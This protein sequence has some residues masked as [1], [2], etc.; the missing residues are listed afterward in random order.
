[1]KLESAGKYELSSRRRALLDALM[2][3]EGLPVGADESIPRR[4]DPSGAPLSFAQQRMWFLEQLEPGSSAYNI[5]I[6]IRMRGPLAIGG[7]ERSLNAVAARH[8]TLRAAF[9]NLDGKAVQRIESRVDVPLPVLDLS[10]TDEGE[11]EV[12]LRKLAAQEADRTFDLR[13]APLIR[14]RLTRLDRDDHVLL[15]TMHHIVSDAWSFG[16][17]LRELGAF[18]RAFLSARAPVLPELPI[19]YADYAEWQTRCLQGEALESQLA[20]W[21]RQL[22]G[23]LP[24]LEL[25]V[26]RLR[27]AIQTYRGARRNIEL[28]RATLESLRELSRSESVTLFTTFLAALSVLL[29]KYSGDEDILIGSPVAGRDK[30]EVENLIGFF[31]NTLVLRMD[32]SGDPSFR[33]VMRRAREVTLEAY[34]H[35]EIPFEKLVDELEPERQLGRNPFF[36]VVLAFQDAPASALTF[37]DLEMSF[38]EVTTHKS[39]FD[40]TLFLW[41]TEQGL[42]GSLEYNTDLF[43]SG[44]AG[45]MV[46]HFETLLER[47]SAEPGTRLADLCL[48]TEEERERILVGWNTTRATYPRD[49]C[50]HEFIQ[51]QA[52]RTPDAV[53]VCREGEN[54]TYRQ[55][56]ER[57]NQIMRRLREL[58]VGPEVLVGVCMERSLEMVVGLLAVLKAG[59]A[60]VALDPDYPKERLA[61]MV[62]DSGVRVVLT[63]RGLSSR[64][65]AHGCRLLF[66]ERGLAA[67][68]AEESTNLSSPA[69]PHNLAYVTYTS[70][71]TGRPKGV[72][73]LHRGVL[74]LL[75]DVHYVR[76]GAE[77]TILQLAPVSFDA[78]TFEIWGALL[79]GGR[80]V[81]HSERVPSPGDLAKVI[82]QQSV[83]TLW[84]TA[85]LFNAIIDE[86]PESLAGLRQ[87]LTGGEALSVPH[88][89]KALKAL[90]STNLINGYGPTEGTTF[91]CC[92]GISPALEEHARSIPIG[93]PIS[94]TRVYILDERMN[95][96]PVGIPG[97]LYIGGDGLGR[98]YLGR[99]GLTAE[100]FVPDPFARE[101]GQRLYRSGDRARYLA[102]GNIEFLGRVDHQVKLRGFRVELG[103]IESVLRRHPGVREAV[104]TIWKKSSGEKRLAAYFTSRSEPPPR[105]DELRRHL[106]SKL[107]DYMVPSDFVPLESMPLG[108]TGKVDRS[109]LPEPEHPG[110]EP[111][112]PDMAPRTLVEEKLVDIWKKVLGV[113]CVG[114]DDNFFSLG[115]DSI[116]T[117]QAVSRAHRA[118]LDVSPKQLFQHQ[119]IR[120]L[121]RV[122]NSSR[123]TVAEQGRVDGAVPLTPIQRWYF[124]HGPEEPGHFNQSMFLEVGC[125]M[126]P[127]VLEKAVEQVLSDH[128]ALR[129]RFV[130]ER[131]GWRQFHGESVGGVPLAMVDLSAIHTEERSSLM[132]SV[133][134]DVQASLDLSK[135][136]LVRCV[137]FDSKGEEA[138]RLLVVIHH[139]V[140]DGVSWR[141][142]L[143]DLETVYE[144][145]Y[146][147]EPAGL[148][149]KTTSYKAWAHRLTERAQSRELED[150][151]EYWN[152]VHDRPSPALPADHPASDG[153]NTE[154]FAE[155]VVVSL[156]VDDTSHLIQEVPRAGFRTE[157]L[158][159]TALGRAL[160]DWTGSSRFWVAMEGHGREGIGGG[161]DLTRTVGWFTSLYP[162][163]LDLGQAASAGQALIR[164]RDALG[165]IPNKGVGYGMLRYSRRAAALSSGAVEPEVSFNYLGRFD[166]ST[167]ERALF[168]A[169]SES[170]GPN[171]CPRQTRRRILDVNGWVSGG[172]LEVR[173]TYSRSLHRRTTI[174]V[175]ARRFVDE[176]RALIAYGLSAPMEESSALSRAPFHRL[177]LDKAM[178]QVEFE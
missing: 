128:D 156:G 22:E 164:V 46:S 121:A 71:S 63:E 130:T 102:D 70:G 95:P 48:L 166:R 61:F 117:I 69:V 23:P 100:K 58:G 107:P 10:G 146:R 37:P 8:E 43:D 4:S 99:P 174:E 67:F 116:L 90:P 105:A 54:L 44:T 113:D 2:R 152:R 26:D 75:M 21:R 120:E 134:A 109:R 55:L 25:P 169:A 81:V 13:R 91:T 126:D 160:A 66:L 7:L 89:R 123:R 24:V 98:G 52:E 42:T 176:L 1:L 142:L 74:R 147:D 144:R 47:L 51:E 172:D 17:L 148:S 158:L 177:E 155:S 167:G 101:A 49:K 129:L 82:A 50:I 162:L 28:S 85:S 34:T 41:E 83:S 161:L 112:R 114:V 104:A 133:A 6:A 111:S 103:E 32:L 92:H 149:P 122:V 20:Y 80:L 39:R 150:E 115:G 151:L 175:L 137:Y 168:K 88:V 72:E 110:R 40:L 106:E 157:E 94:G 33:E 84:L 76:L 14:A 79:H 132:E 159:L 171:R 19:Q 125:E 119:T 145:L 93:R 56:N 57:S 118:G 141:I 45:R 27:P 60:Y 30:M 9:D 138:G 135:G 154:A 131:F 62:K 38:M 68:S 165:R 16:V 64:L 73:V 108:H 86:A 136:P 139:L 78:S 173:F 127:L 163:H 59:G 36:Q 29:N 77:E 178:G 11:R 97:E 3:E 5:P 124:E 15:M 18:Y 170:T 31:V 65:P 12:L 87:L 140:V 35:Q 53:A 96:V 143:E 153:G